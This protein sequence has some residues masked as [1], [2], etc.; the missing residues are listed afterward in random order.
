MKKI[1]SICLI[2]CIVLGVL[3]GCDSTNSTDNAQKETG[4][5]VE[6]KYMSEVLGYYNGTPITREDLKSYTV[7][8]NYIGADFITYEKE[9]VKNYAF[10]KSV[11]ELLK[12]VVVDDAYYE[13]QTAT[14]KEYAESMDIT[15]DMYIAYFYGSEDNLKAQLKERK[16]IYDLGK[17]LNISEETVK[18]YYESATGDFDRASL[19]VIYFADVETYDKGIALFES[20]KSLEE[21][22]K[23]LDIEIEKDRM[24]YFTSDLTWSTP[25]E[26]ANVGDTIYTMN[27]S[28]DITLA[29]GTLNEKISGIDNPDVYADVYESCLYNEGYAKAQENLSEILKNVKF[30]ALGETISLYTEQTDVDNNSGSEN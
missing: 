19:D 27:T 30:E 8:E 22:S 18:E 29:I 21:I 25:L 10:E 20:G 14:L 23:E 15:W 26:D 13:E 6:N 5:E 4:S 16:Y 3:T 24:T 28:D 2:L 17:S 1:L 7:S 9:M 12:D 11:E